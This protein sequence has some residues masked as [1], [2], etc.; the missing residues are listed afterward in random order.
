[1]A[2]QHGPDPDPYRF[3]MPSR[4][5]PIVIIGAGGIVRDAHLPAYA[6]YGFPVHA[7]V[8]RTRSRAEALAREFGVANVFDEL[9]AAVESAPADAVFDIALMPEQYEQ[10]LAALPRGAGVLIQKPLGHDGAQARR[11]RDICRDR[12]LVAAVNTQLRFAPYVEAARRALAAGEIGELVD[13]E[14]RVTVRQP[15]ELFPHVFELPR[16]ELNMHSVHYLDLVR[17]FL[18]DP[19]D[20][21]CLTLP[22]PERPYANCRSTILLR[23]GDRPLRVVIATNHEHDFGPRYEESFVKF[24]GT[25]GALRIQMGLLLDYPRG[26]P[27]RLEIARHDRRSEGWQP[28]PFTGSWFPDAFAGS[29]GVLQRALAGD[30]TH[31]PTSVDDVVRTMDLV[32]AAHA[33]SDRG[34]VVP[35]FDP[36][37]PARPRVG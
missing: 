16:L 13:L 4:L 23:Y 25:R 14:I 9:T 19:S 34:G 30:V 28:L 3:A 31:L 20:V 7:L 6:R 26:G 21:M 12:G 35:T 29:M 37:P 32:D 18:G 1:M 33:S 22:H 15:W 8:N 17:S 10:T 24:E 27:D 5:R 36:D 2:P 11:I